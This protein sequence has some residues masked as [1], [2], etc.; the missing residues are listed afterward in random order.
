MCWIG[1]LYLKSH[2]ISSN[3]NTPP[4]GSLT[5]SLVLL[6]KHLP[7][8]FT[9]MW[10]VRNSPYNQTSEGRRASRLVVH[11]ITFIPFCTRRPEFKWACDGL[12]QLLHIAFFESKHVNMGEEM[13]VYVVLRALITSSDNPHTLLWCSYFNVGCYSIQFSCTPYNKQ[14]GFLY[15]REGRD[16]YFW[17]PAQS[18]GCQ[19]K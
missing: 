16:V 8:I 18:L 5:W 1:T 14:M 3:P 10:N 15:F 12:R 4:L 17:T 7:L 6:L 19:W 2:N 13:Y 11:N 9:L